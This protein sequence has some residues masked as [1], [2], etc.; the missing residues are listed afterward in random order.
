VSSG[1]V[2]GVLG[3]VRRPPTTCQGAE[4]PTVEFSTDKAKAGVWCYSCNGSPQMGG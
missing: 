3:S 2:S 4:I 1:G